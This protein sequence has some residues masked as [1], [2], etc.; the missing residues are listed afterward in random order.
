MIECPR[1]QGKSCTYCPARAGEE[2]PLDDQPEWM[3]EQPI[4]AGTTGVCAID[5]PECDSC[6]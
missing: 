4:S 5:N 3:N 2:C 6:Q 1:E